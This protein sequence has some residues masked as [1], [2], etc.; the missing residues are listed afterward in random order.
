[1]VKY[2]EIFVNALK[3]PQNILLLVLGFIF[4]IL[5]LSDLIINK[6]FP[7]LGAFLFLVIIAFMAIYV[8][9]R[10][11][12]PAKF[13]DFLTKRYQSP[14]AGV[15]IWMV[16][17]FLI[18]T[19]CFIIKAFCNRRRFKNYESQYANLPF[20]VL[21]IVN[22]HGRVV[23]ATN[24]TRSL[25]LHNRSVKSIFLN[26]QEIPKRKLFYTLHQ[27]DEV[28]AVNIRIQK[29]DEEVITY[30][31]QKQNLY[32]KNFYN[33]F[34]IYRQESSISTVIQET[35]APIKV[36]V[37]NSFDEPIGY[38]D[39][40]TKKM[41][42]NQKM[43]S[44]L[45]TNK[46][47]LSEDEFMQFVLPEDIK[48]Y[49]QTKEQRPQ[50]FVFRLG[51]KNAK[52]WFEGITDI[53]KTEMIIR[54]TS[55]INYRSKLIVK[56]HK[57]L[58]DDIKKFKTENREFGLIALSF[59]N[60]M[61]QTEIEGMS[62]SNLFAS[63]YFKNLLE[64]HLKDSVFVYQLGNIEFGLLINN[65]ITLDILT[66]EIVE[67]QEQF[68]VAKY[69][70]NNKLVE[71]DLAL[72]VVSSKNVGNLPAED[73]VTA[74]YEA[75]LEASDPNYPNNYSIYYPKTEVVREYRLEDFDIDL[76]E[77]FLEKFKIDD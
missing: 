48:F 35:K 52:A 67:Q 13:L 17:F 1:M 61:D 28:E 27:Q 39:F 8:L 69:M 46:V 11:I 36:D 16:Y 10:N 9:K 32:K 43:Q 44:F 71:V 77:S 23:Y 18:S 47:V 31:F 19:F 55:S 56:S 45:Q 63:N 20:E 72:G 34:I 7:Y 49:E 54:L 64:G 4:G 33:G 12:I 53:N 75:L 70:V 41:Y 3:N 68:R 40:F 65:P 62:L 5:L 30:N 76:S 22:R 15:M 24:S 2:F 29:N 42:L 21:W 37:I 74:S 38:L 60:L 73:I 6:K 57:D 25:V 66:K 26:E 51:T 14:K 58:I 59:V 50:K